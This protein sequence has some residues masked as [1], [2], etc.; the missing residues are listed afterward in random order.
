MATESLHH[1]LKAR[2]NLTER[3]LQEVLAR[4][5]EEDLSWA[6][7]PDMRTVRGQLL[8][9]A[10]KEREVLK[11]IQTGTWPDDDP[12][13]FDAETATLSEIKSAVLNLRKA[14]FT[15]IDSLSDAELH[16]LHPSPQGW[17]EA[18]RLTECP[19]HEILRN[20]SVHEWYH[21]GQLVAYLWSR[22]DDPESW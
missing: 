19:V 15:Y 21:T 8:E 18:L 9:I 22:G 16:R 14:T 3:Y 20:I 4:L 1:L 13:T 11:W 17:W 5:K 10:D 12:P 6:P 2:F 7:T